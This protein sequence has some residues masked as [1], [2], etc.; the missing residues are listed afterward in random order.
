MGWRELY[1]GQSTNV[2]QRWNR[3]G[4]WRHQ[5]LSRWE[6]GQQIMRLIVQPCW[7]C[8]LD[9]REARAIDQLRPTLNRTRPKPRWTLLVLAEDL[10]RS[11]PWLGVVAL[12]LAIAIK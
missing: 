4:G 8:N 12:G 9:Y 2:H 6:R 5:H 1:A 11:L 3:E 10:W 7:E